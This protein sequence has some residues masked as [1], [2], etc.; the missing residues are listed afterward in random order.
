MIAKPEK[1]ELFRKIKLISNK[2]R[3]Q[4]VQLT[5]ENNLSITEISTKLKLAYNKCADYI[6]LLEQEGLVTKTKE[7]KEIKVK[8]KVKLGEN[9]IEFV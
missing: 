5:Q 2:K 4:I 7:G 1:T 9:K 3:F 6:T 8:S